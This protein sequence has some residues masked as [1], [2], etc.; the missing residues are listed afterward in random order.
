MRRPGR[1]DELTEPIESCLLS[2]HTEREYL[3]SAHGARAGL[4]DKGLITSYSG[5]FL[6]NLIFRLQHLYIVEEDCRT[7]KGFI[8]RNIGIEIKF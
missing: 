3:C 5:Y 2:G 6:R 1:D 8:C 4:V 7:S